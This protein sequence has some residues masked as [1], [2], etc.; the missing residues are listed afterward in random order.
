MKLNSLLT[1]GLIRT[2]FD[3]KLMGRTIEKHL[4]LNNC[5][6]Q[7]APPELQSINGVCE[8]NWRSILRMARSWLASALLP[9]NF[10]WFALKRATEVSNYIPIKR[11]ATLTTPHELVYGSK[12]DLRNLLPMFA[13]AYTSYS[14]PHSYDT[15]SV[16]TILVGRS[17]KSNAVLFYHPTTKQLLTS[18][19]YKLDEVHT[20]GPAFGLQYEGGMYINKYIDKARQNDAPA[21]NPETTVY[22]KHNGNIIQAEVIT[23][24]LSN[25]LYTIQYEDESIHQHKEMDLSSSNPT[26]TP[27]SQDLP[28]NI[29]PDWIKQNGKCTLFLHSMSRPKH[30]TITKINEEWHF[31]PGTRVSNKPIHLEHFEQNMHDLIRTALLQKG[32]PNFTKVYQLRSSYSMSK[33]VAKHVA[34]KG[35]Q[36]FDPPTLSQHKNLSQND[37][38]IWDE[39]YAEEYIGLKQLPAWTTIT[40]K[41][42]K[43]M[44][45]KYRTLL[46]TMAIST[47]KYDENNNPKRAKYRIVVLGNLDP[48]EWTKQECYAPVISLLELRLLTSIAVHFRKTLKSGD[49]KQ[50]FVQA[51]LPDNERYILRPPAGCPL[52]P[53]NSYW[54]LK[55]T[56]YGLKRSPRHWYDRISKLLTDIGLSKCPNAPCIFTG[57]IIQGKSPLYLGLYVDDFV[58]F[59]ESTEVEEAFEKKLGKLTK[60]DFM[61]TVSHFLG[62]KFQWRLTENNV[63]VH[64]SQEAF[65]ENLIQQAG[66]SSESTTVTRTPYRSGCPVDS[67][68]DFIPPNPSNTSSQLETEM[69][70]YVGS[71]LWLSQGTR[72]DL[73][74]ITNILAQ[75]QNCPTKRHITSAKF[76]IKYLKGTKS[77]GITFDSDKDLKLMA[78]LNFPLPSD[79]ITGITDAN[80]GPQDQSVPKSYQ[81]PQELKLF[82]T[83]SLSGHLIFLHGPIHWMSKRQKIT[84]CSSGEAEIYATDMCVRDILFIRNIIKDLH[85]DKYFFN[86]K[87][88]IY[89]DNM[90]C[91]HWA[92]NTTSKGLRYI[93]IKENAIRELSHLFDIKHIAGKQN[94]ADLLSKEDKDTMHFTMFRDQLVPK[95]YI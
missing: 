24:P 86:P 89:N 42:F 12:P 43:N 85:M 32:H 73:A 91:I 63:K 39:A 48:Y 14:S 66:L 9:S 56:L 58:Y 59:L 74:T 3:Y 18:T 25:D 71:L 27:S 82:K 10:W 26:T 75:Y 53:P 65:S 33:I 60:V 72:P 55:R 23:V 19:R 41:E 50:A 44:H 17:N 36:C 51:I 6:L 67:L 47:V 70:S 31:K 76:A 5:Q 49:V 81:P 45:P 30:G 61:G 40:E 38:R 8:R 90:A 77:H 84:A 78:Y 92:K 22:L 57:T 79:K 69:R 16:K 95:P 88:K 54:L 11:D 20:A 80:W 93:Q 34:A 4:E 64:L 83:R 87:T 13:I 35:F 52:T 1:P 68:P 29:F 28:L 62:I 7:S 37:K 46:P 21:F 2:D 15:Q 94:P